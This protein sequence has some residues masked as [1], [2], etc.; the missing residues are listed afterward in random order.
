MRE[1]IQPWQFTQRDISLSMIK[2][3]LPKPAAK[4]MDFYRRRIL[5]LPSGHPLAWIGLWLIF[6]CCAGSSIAQNAVSNQSW[7]ELRFTRT[8]GDKW[9][10]ELNLSARFSN[11]QED[12]SIFATYIQSFYRGWIHYQYSP[13]WK[14]STFLAYYDNKN[15]PEINQAASSEWRFAVQGIYYI[16]KIGYTLSTRGRIELRLLN[17]DNGTTDDVFRYRQQ[18]KYQKPINSKSLRQGVFYAVASDELFFRST[19]KSTGLSHF[20]RNRLTAGIGY[21][22]TNDLHVEL[23]YVNEFLPRDG[24]DQIVNALFFK[25][26]F[27]NLLPR[28]RKQLVD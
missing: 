19:T 1:T 12:N 8:I 27:N 18:L 14:F 9:I 20:D 13:R 28:L 5:I 24:S 4:T 22:I 2:V 10:G 21:V 25:C 17:K 6:T 11:T 16:H 26:T 7:N 3:A 23:A 15:S